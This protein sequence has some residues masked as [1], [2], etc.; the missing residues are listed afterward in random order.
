MD[1]TYCAKAKG[2]RDDLGFRHTTAT[3]PFLREH[4]CL[5]C[6]TK[7]HL[8][9]TCRDSTKLLRF[10]MACSKIRNDSVVSKMAEM[11]YEVERMRVAC[12]QQYLQERKRCNFCI[13]RWPDGFYKTHN[14]NTCPRLASMVCAHCRCT[15]HMERYCPGKTAAAWREAATTTDYELSFEDAENTMM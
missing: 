14:V 1:C 15:G 9:H 7:G 10:Q 11:E 13:H 4:V 2:R 8:A 3:C 5:R 6:Y 12:M